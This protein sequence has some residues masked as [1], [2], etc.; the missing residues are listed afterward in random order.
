MEFLMLILRAFSTKWSTRSVKVT[1]CSWIFNTIVKIYTHEK[2]VHIWAVPVY[3][4]SEGLVNMAF[5][6][7]RKSYYLIDMAVDYNL[8][9]L[10]C[11]SSSWKS[12]NPDYFNL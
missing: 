7:N 1:Q 8:C 10:A 5:N 3:L 12:L 2:A 11:A 4:R 6:R 9:C